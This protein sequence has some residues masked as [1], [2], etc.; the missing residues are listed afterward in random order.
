MLEKIKQMDRRVLIM[1]MVS[2]ALLV[3]ALISLGVYLYQQHQNDLAEEAYEKL[4]DTEEVE[5]PTEEATPQHDFAALQEQ[6]SEIYAWVAVPDTLVDYPVLQSEEDNYYLTHDISGEVTTAGAIYSN[7]C[8]SLTMSD[9]ITIF[10]GH[11]MRADTMF[12]SLH[13]FDEQ[14]FFNAHETVT[15]ET[16]EALYTYQIVGV[17]NYNDYYLPALFDVKTTDGAAD[18]LASLED[19]A[20]EGSAITHVRKGVEVTEDD[21]LLV[22]S[23]CISGQDDRRFLVVSKLLETTSYVE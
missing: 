5:E 12:G 22:L 10:Y 7:A 6:N 8:N 19:C 18:F 17:Y 14:D 2:V 4:R 13:L 3:A 21:T 11:D 1:R 23:T 16:T 20:E 15:V 9:S